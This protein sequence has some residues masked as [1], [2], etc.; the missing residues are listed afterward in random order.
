MG[1]EMEREPD[2]GSCLASVW[3][4]WLSNFQHP[5]ALNSFSCET[6]TALLSLKQ[7]PMIK[8]NYKKVAYKI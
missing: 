7:F 5:S 6:A 1:A 2:I 8:F 3:W 4:R